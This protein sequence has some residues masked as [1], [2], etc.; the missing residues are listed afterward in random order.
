MSRLDRIWHPLR[1]WWRRVVRPTAAWRA[2]ARLES[3]TMTDS[4]ATLS[5]YAML[6]LFPGLLLAMTIIGLVGGED[7]VRQIVSF[8]REQGADSATA[9][10]VETVA[11][12]AT[13]ISSGALTAS[14]LLSTLLLVN[15]ASGIFH[16][17]GR[18]VNRAHDV[19]EDRGF[20]RRRIVV[21]VLTLIVVL[22]LVISMVAIFLGG[23]I[24][25]DIFGRIGLGGEAQDV[26]AI[27]RWPVALCMALAAVSI[28][29]RYAPAEAAQRRHLVTSGSIV[30]V[31]LWVILTA[32]FSVYVQGF[33]RYGALY[34]VFSTAVILLLWAYLMAIAFLYG[35]ELDGELRRRRVARDMLEGE[36]GAT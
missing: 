12:S 25:T 1:D 10:V 16:A 35:A 4:A 20:V 2:L 22:L 27:V 26:W 15:S 36:P 7:L 33:S 28:V 3:D 29:L 13:Q 17:A 32:G 18:A 31:V 24:A 23:G 11:R 34:G 9:T 5:Y 6:S 21:V 14:L 30:T 8:A 19:E